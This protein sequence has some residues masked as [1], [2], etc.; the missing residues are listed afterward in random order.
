LHTLR[1]S[2]QYSC[3]TGFSLPWASAYANTAFGHRI[4]T[5]CPRVLGPLSLGLDLEES[6]PRPRW[7][8]VGM[9]PAGCRC[10]RNDQ[11]SQDWPSLIAHRPDLPQLTS[12]PELSIPDASW[13]AESPGRA[14]VTE[15]PRMGLPI[16]LQP[17]AARWT[18]SGIEATKRVVRW[19][20]PSGPSPIECCRG[21]VM[22][23]LSLRKLTP[24][25]W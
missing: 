22:S 1:C 20:V 16:S 10:R 15:M 6:V 9:L 23:C 2:T 7:Y 17:T 24:G 19:R 13:D 8:R 21:G 25:I 18:D 3:P 12:R 4:H 14:F 11:G 5:A